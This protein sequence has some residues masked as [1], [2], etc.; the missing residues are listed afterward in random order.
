VQHRSGRRR[1]KGQEVI[2]FT[3]VLPL[4]LL[5]LLGIMEFA[6]AVLAYNSVAHAA[7]EGARYGVIHPEDTAGI[8]A[9]VQEA[10]VALDSNEFQFNVSLADGAVHVEVTYDHDLLIAPVVQAIGGNPT[11]QMHTVATM[12]V[13]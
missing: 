13:E 5:L 8:V 1:E 6:I 3:L 10:A 7:R 4:L 9:R 11:I 2:E 12:Y